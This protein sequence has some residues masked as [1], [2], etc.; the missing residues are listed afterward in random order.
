MDT[1]TFIAELVKALAWPLTVMIILLLLRRQ[2]AALIPALQRFRYRDLEFE[3]NREVQELA[4]RARE[5][6]PAQPIEARGL[7]N[8][9]EL[10]Q[11]SPRAV[12][13]ESWLQLEKAAMQAARRHNANLTSRELKAPLLLGKALENLGVLADE[14]A[15]IYHRL[16]NL[17]NAAAHASDYSFEPEAALEYADLAY[18][19]SDYL[20][21]A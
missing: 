13:L 9:Q 12:V 8:L 10:A 1:L 21:Q 2:I 15:A 5:Q 14:T 11:L 3:F 19:L 7:A 16:R 6:I 4:V 20:E 18:R 17:R